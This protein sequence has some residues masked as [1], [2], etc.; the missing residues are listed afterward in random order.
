MSQHRSMK[1]KVRLSQDVEVSADRPFISSVIKTKTIILKGTLVY[2]ACD[3]EKCYL[4]QK[5]GCLLE[6][7]SNASGSG[8]S[9]GGNST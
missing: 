9:A 3:S 4:P 6:C 8:E 2:Q 7:A 5:P 1:G